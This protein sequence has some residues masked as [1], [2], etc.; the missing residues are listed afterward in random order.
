[1]SSYSNKTT[2]LKK[3]TVTFIQG[4]LRILS[5]IILIIFLLYFICVFRERVYV[6]MHVRETPVCFLVSLGG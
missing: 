5:F 2:K 3:I 1:M 6:C 4:M